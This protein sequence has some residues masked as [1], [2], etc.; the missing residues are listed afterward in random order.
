MDSYVGGFTQTPYQFGQARGVLDGYRDRERNERHDVYMQNQSH[1]FQTHRDAVQQQ[2]HVSNT[3]L[4]TALDIHRDNNSATNTMK[5]GDRNAHLARR[6]SGQESGQRKSE[7][8]QAHENRLAE[9]YQLHNHRQHEAE[10]DHVNAEA[11][12]TNA[13]GREE[14]GRD[15]QAGREAKVEASRRK[16]ET[17]N[18]T[19]GMSDVQTL[20]ENPRVG[21]ASLNADG[22]FNLTTRDKPKPRASRANPN[23]PPADPVAPEK[24]EP[25]PRASRAKTPPAEPSSG[26]AGGV[27]APGAAAQRAGY[28]GRHTR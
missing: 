15:S 20:A 14:A 7:A 21:N 1:A 26:P 12:A 2:Y 16:R 8:Q 4:G 3:V 22:S 24:K 18:R 13:F 19:R 28:G 6:L 9:N 25:R 5:Q 10:G 11:K 27:G 23:T 17:E